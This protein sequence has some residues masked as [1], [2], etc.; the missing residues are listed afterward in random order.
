[1][2]AWK[3]GHQNYMSETKRDF[4]TSNQQSGYK[5]VC[6]LAAANPNLAEYLAQ[7]ESELPMKTPCSRSRNHMVQRHDRAL[8]IAIETLSLYANPESYH[9]IMM[10]PD[11]PSGWF[12]RDVSKTN[13]PH[14]NRKMHGAEAR[15]ALAKIQKLVTP[16]KQTHP[17]RNNITKRKLEQ[18]PEAGKS[19]TW[20][21]Q[22]AWLANLESAHTTLQTLREEARKDGRRSDA[23]HYADTQWLIREAMNVEQCKSAT[24]RA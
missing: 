10:L 17:Q 13:H 21:G 7:L 3:R 6:E 22:V 18:W 14:Y 8:V 16:N 20:T 5:S 19:S 11:S 24:R 15:K 9:A 1:M 12:A 23:Q 2:A 4:D